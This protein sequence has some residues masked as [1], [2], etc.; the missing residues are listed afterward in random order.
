[1]QQTS[2]RTKGIL[3][4]LLGPSALWLALFFVAPLL[5]VLVAIIQVP[6]IYG[7]ATLV[8]AVGMPGGASRDRTLPSIFSE[9]ESLSRAILLLAGGLALAVAIVA[10]LA[11]LWGM[12]LFYVVASP[13]LGA[14]LLSRGGLLVPA[15]EPKT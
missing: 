11:P 13:G 14:A 1:M 12:A 4:F 15:Y 7:L 8:R 2:R 5:I 3:A 10:G 6:Y 9:G